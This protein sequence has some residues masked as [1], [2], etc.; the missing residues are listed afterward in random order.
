[1]SEERIPLSDRLRRIDR[2]ERLLKSSAGR[3]VEWGSVE[4]GAVHLNELSSVDFSAVEL[5]VVELSS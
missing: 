3:E 1:M 4:F 5:N 2:K